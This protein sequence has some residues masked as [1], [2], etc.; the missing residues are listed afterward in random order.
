M[1][2]KK[3]T[4][5]ITGVCGMDGSTLADKLIKK[6]YNVIGL[7]R[8]NPTGFGD[9]LKD[10]LTHENF[11]L[12]TGDITEKEYITRI[13]RDYKPDYFYNMAAISLVP[14]SFKIPIRVFETNC[15]AVLYMLEAIRTYSPH[16]RFYQ[17]STSEQIGNTVEPL[18]N[19]E[20][21]M[22]P[23]SP[24]A[25]AKL[26]SYHLVRSYR[27]A[28][29][30]FACNGMLW[31]HEGSVPRDSSL[32]IKH[33]NN[34]IE[35]LPIEDL[36]KSEKHR[37]EGLLD[38][39]TGKEVWNGEDWTTILDGQAYINR[40][41]ITN[42]VNTVD[43]SYEA[44]LAHIVFDENN[45]E[46]PTEELDL[47]HKLFKTSYPINSNILNNMDENLATFIG[48]VVGDG[49]ITSQGRI[50]LTGTNK[51]EIVQ[52]AELVTKMYG[53]T[54]TISESKSGLS[55]SYDCKKVYKLSI[56]N[57]KNFGLWIKENIYT[58]YMLSYRFTASSTKTN[59][60]DCEFL[61]T[62]PF[63]VTHWQPL[64]EQPKE[65]L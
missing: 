16:T 31:N 13:I 18:Q 10:A 44:T 2:E 54:Y 36:F 14:E 32:I 38:E 1:S 30:L 48:F 12:E 26:A 58:T 46:L 27:N 65:T 45:N 43:S 41:K 7:G 60:W 5:V 51:K 59:E 57:D 9:N 52:M 28:H 37:H 63:I 40:E 3:K 20:S 33:K 6:G 11:K 21:K 47:G 23:N 35:I 29:G 15:L 34:L 42:I 17:A 39:Y 4:V 25:I 55:D 24:Y 61:K 19:T 22:L 56:N 53:W 49:D 64:P 8:W 50:R 62:Y